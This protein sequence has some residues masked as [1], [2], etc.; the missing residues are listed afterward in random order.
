MIV[1]LD[2]SQMRS[3]ALAHDHLMQK[4]RFPDYYGRNLDALY[5]LLTARTEPTEIQVSHPEILLELLGDY[6]HRLIRTLEEAAQE[7][8]FLKICIISENNT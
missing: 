2:G 8:Q 6:G 3:R 4:L 7:N 1:E 5:D